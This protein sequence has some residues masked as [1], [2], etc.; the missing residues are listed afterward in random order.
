MKVALVAQSMDVRRGGAETSTLQFA[1][2]LLRA[3]I[4]LHLITQGGA[5]AMDGLIVHTL[6]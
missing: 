6:G 4:D 5:P 2:H 1:G 3:G